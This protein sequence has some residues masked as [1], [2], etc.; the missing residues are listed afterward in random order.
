MCRSSSAGEVEGVISLQNIDR[1]NAFD[2]GDVRL[3]TTLASSMSV[4]LE[5]AR[6]FNETQRLLE[7]TRQRNRELAVISRLGQAL[8]G[9]LDPQ[10]IYELVGEEVRQV[11]D[12]QVVAII[13]YDR[14]SDLLLYRYSIEKSERQNVAPRPPG[15]FAGHIL[16]TRQPLL[17]E[18]D[19]ARRA[20]EL[21]ST[22]VAGE[23]PR[24]YLGVPLVAGGEVTGVISLQNIDREAAFSEDDLRLLSTLALSM[25]VALE[26]A[27]LYQETQRRATEMATLAEIGSDI[28]S[29]HELEPVLERLVARTRDLMNVDVIALYM[30]QP[31]GRTMRAVA[32]S[33][34]YADEWRGDSIRVDESITGRVAQTGIAEIVN[35]PERDPRFRTVPGTEADEAAGRNV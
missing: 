2:E 33:G 19:L 16:A 23:L 3:L 13:T 27:R 4:A 6:L 8:V 10:G 34:A 1:E 31:D 12:A 24:S 7:E 17:I 14:Q 32:V 22:V 35:Y 15:G 18:R 11:F 29:T 5:N 9:Q 30:L 26:N 20:A 28:A 21:G 25:G